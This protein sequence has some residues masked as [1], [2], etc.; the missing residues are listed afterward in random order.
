MAVFVVILLAMFVLLGGINSKYMLPISLIT[1][2]CISPGIRVFGITFVNTLFLCFILISFFKNE[3][4][5]RE[6]GIGRMYSQLIKY[7]LLIPIPF[8]FL[9]DKI[10]YVT[11]LQFYK[12][13][14]SLLFL[15]SLWNIRMTYGRKSNR[16]VMLTILI[17]CIYGIFS[18]IT[19]TNLYAEITSQLYGNDF[20]AASMAEHSMEDSRANL[21]G[22]ITGTAPY[23][24]QYCI[25]MGI[26]IFYLYS[27][28]NFYNR[29]VIAMLIVLC[30]INM[31]L[32]GSRGPI[33]ALIIGFLYYISKNVT[34]RYKVCVIIFTIIFLFLFKGLLSL[35]SSETNDTGSSPEGRLVQIYGCWLEVNYSLKSIL[36]GLGAG[37][38]Q[39][40]LDN[41]G[42]HPIAAG[43]EG[44]FLSGLV[45]HGII[46][47]LFIDIVTW[48]LEI[49][50][51]IRAYKSKFIAS[52][53]KDYLIGFVLFEII[54]SFLEGTAYT[55]LYFI[56]FTMI[57]KYSSLKNSKE[58]HYKI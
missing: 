27:L 2:F 44:R 58:V 16:A 39:F 6:D 10:D 48:L 57:L 28:R 20:D 53:D 15:F 56:V 36:F 5:I 50:L 31:Y 19:S 18:Y 11:Q 8:M 40:Y 49:R 35:F 13:M 9:G 51:I 12:G 41:Y 22:R 32:T 47:I 34:V 30:F 23:T 43:F 1:L 26:A 52:K 17:I 7:V 54:Y 4:F 21:K 46:G 14:I 42:M 3:F 37:Y 45:N 38:N 29:I 55:L 25:L 33:L 24:I